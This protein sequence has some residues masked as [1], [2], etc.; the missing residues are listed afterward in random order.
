MEF[1]FKKKQLKKFTLKCR[2]VELFLYPISLYVQKPI[3]KIIK[4]ENTISGP[5]PS[6]LIPLKI[7]SEKSPI[8]LKISVQVTMKA[9]IFVFF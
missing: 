8:A 1:R 2:C 4:A 9:F 3:A 5:N 7:Q 6:D